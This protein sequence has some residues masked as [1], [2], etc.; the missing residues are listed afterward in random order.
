MC[1]GTG[2]RGLVGLFSSDQLRAQRAYKDLLMKTTSN[3]FL[4]KHEGEFPF[5]RDDRDD[6][7]VGSRSSEGSSGFDYVLYDG[8]GC[9]SEKEFR[10]LPVTAGRRRRKA[11]TVESP[12]GY[13]RQTKKI[14]KS[15]RILNYQYDVIEFREIVSFVFDLIS[16]VCM[17]NDTYFSFES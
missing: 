15:N 11:S 1:T 10:S 12:G 5:P 6:D 17:P 14:S 8:A 2:S 13:L 16:Y 4:D 7:S 9:G 3:T